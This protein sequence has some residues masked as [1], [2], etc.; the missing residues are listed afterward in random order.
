MNN[1]E[2]M[3]A[4]PLATPEMLDALM[5]DGIAETVPG[6]MSGGAEAGIGGE[7]PR[8]LGGSGA[9]RAIRA[10]RTAAATRYLRIMGLSPVNVDGAEIWGFGQGGGADW[11]DG[12]AALMAQVAREVLSRPE[13]VPEEQIA[14]RL[15]RIAEI[16]SVRMRVADE[17]EP[18]AWLPKPDRDR[19]QEISRREAYGRYFSIEEISLRHRLHDGRWSPVLDREV[20]ISADAALLLP[21]DPVR[22]RVLLI[23][24]FRMGPLAR[25]QAQCWMLEPVAGRI[26]A[27]ETAEASALREAAEEAGL[28]IGQVHALPGYYPTPGAHSEFFYPFVG[29]ADLPDTIEGHGFGL[30]DEGEDISTHLMSRQELVR[31][32]LGGQLQCGPLILM[33]LW[34][35]RN[36][37]RI[38]AELAGS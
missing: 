26:D 38:R 29:I 25:G 24:Q 1:Q 33:T 35:D 21:Y 14:S 13:D 19:V 34:L 23:S 4:G 32:A 22:D 9:I 30:D 16:V 3:L 8:Y 5:L 18:T 15:S 17:P 31:L 2:I 36:A 12:N 20:F 10:K 6:A 27:G 11:A 37:D 7:W 28:Q